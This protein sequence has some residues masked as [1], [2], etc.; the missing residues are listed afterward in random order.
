MSQ[1]EKYTREFKAQVVLEAVSDD[2]Q[3][4][5]VAEKHGV[6]PSLLLDWA[7]RMDISHEKLDRLREELGEEEPLQVVELI[8]D[9][10][11]LVDELRYGASFDTLNMGRL[12]YWV[13][14]GVIFFVSILIG[15]TWIFYFN[16]FATT[17]QVAEQS[18]F[19]QITR[20]KQQEQEHLSSFGV[21]DGEEG[22]YHIPVEQAIE[23]ILSE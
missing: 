7:D 12:R 1:E 17:H 8:T 5:E 18:D 14:Y 13:I 23:R 16:D 3:P 2:A 10:S 19:Y 20:I 4:R 22:V 11:V 21:I 6:N 9:D 15:L